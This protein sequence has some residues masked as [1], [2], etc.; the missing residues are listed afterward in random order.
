MEWAKSFLPPMFFN[1]ASKYKKKTSQLY[2]TKN[3]EFI[4]VKIVIIF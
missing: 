4:L 3:Y 1:K 2:I